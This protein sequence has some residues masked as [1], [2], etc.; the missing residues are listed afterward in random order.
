MEKT[1]SGSVDHVRPGT[2]D[3]LA[4]YSIRETPSESES[5]GI[6]SSPTGEHPTAIAADRTNAWLRE[7][8]DVP[9]WYLT[10]K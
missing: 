1:G 5:V 6:A 2:A 9:A 4:A 7:I 8:V 10:Q 3:K